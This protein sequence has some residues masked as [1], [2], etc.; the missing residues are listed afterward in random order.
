MILYEIFP[1]CQEDK[2]TPHT[3]SIFI[4]CLSTF[5]LDKVRPSNRKKIMVF[6]GQEEEEGGW[7]SI[8]SF[9]FGDIVIPRST[10]H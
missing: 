7:V 8:T 2:Y 9:I 10:T 1:L 4:R 6:W 3:K 5:T